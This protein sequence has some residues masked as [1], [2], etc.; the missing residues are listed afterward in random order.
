MFPLFVHV[1][2][3]SEFPIRYKFP[4]DFILDVMQRNRYSNNNIH[5]EIRDGFSQGPQLI[6]IPGF[7][8]IN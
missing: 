1:T 6:S 4:Y 3:L 8:L 5:E 7:F 2:V